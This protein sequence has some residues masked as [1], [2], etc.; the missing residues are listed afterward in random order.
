MSRGQSRPR[1]Q[2]V[3]GV[4][5]RCK[6]RD[7]IEIIDVEKEKIDVVIVDV[8]ETCHQGS[9]HTGIT[10]WNGSPSGVI[11][12]DDEDGDDNNTFA[13]TDAA[14]RE[15]F[16]ASNNSPISEESKSDECII[17]SRKRNPLLKSMEY[18]KNCH[19]V[20]PSNNHFGL[21]SCSKSYSSDSSESNSSKFN[22]GSIYTDSNSS[23]CEI[24]DDSSG[25]VR[26]MW[27]RA[28]SRKKL[29]EK[30]R[31][32]SDQSSASGS[33]GDS[34]L[35]PGGE[36]H[37]KINVE[38][39]IKKIYSDPSK[40]IPVE[41]CPNLSSR[42]KEKL[43][44]NMFGDAENGDSLCNRNVY[45]ADLDVGNLGC[46]E[47]EHKSQSTCKNLSDDQGPHFLASEVPCA[48]V[49]H[50]NMQHDLNIQDDSVSSFEQ[51]E[52]VFFA[53]T[54]AAD[55]LHGESS[56]CSNVGPCSGHVSPLNLQ[57][58]DGE[59]LKLDRSIQGKTKRFHGG[60]S[61]SML[62]QCDS[63]ADPKAFGLQEKEKSS[64]DVPSS[65]NY[66]YS[67]ALQN[68]DGET[69]VKGP[70]DC[71]TNK[72]SKAGVSVPDNGPEDTPEVC[73]NLICER[74]RH[75]ES[76]EY[77]HAIKE[78]WAA[79]QRQL[80]IQAEEAQ[81]MKRKRKAETL[82]LLDMER[83]QKQRLEEI[84]ESQKKD[85][86]TIN[87]KEHIR[88]EVRKELDKMELRYRDMASLL[89]GLGIHVGGG[90]FP[91]PCE[92]NA[93]YKQALLKFHPDRA[94]RSDIHQQV[95]AEE[96]FKMISRLKEKF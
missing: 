67:D 94:S 48:S 88:S 60:A 95:K 93:A 92:V 45:A 58:D 52:S 69:T 46:K 23:D 41:F 70:P 89:R 78:E 63:R 34:G 1:N 32:G 31:C 25:N 55:G 76:D 8:E 4:L 38:N 9:R 54:F 11:N 74:E 42:G 62:P 80:Q 14:D 65:C 30:W 24:I 26:E 64:F 20:G 22:S 35:S 79:R 91:M 18:M 12:I 73:T 15:F 17:T 53:T 19:G 51:D 6:N 84:R 82:R 29:S 77:R 96:T 72:G 40:E 28:A 27:E 57:P 81:R 71:D 33:S 7:T 3:R 85:E 39:C 56:F 49:C 44:F 36:T 21:Y 59:R 10:R 68:V 47:P 16:P 50:T 13:Y 66:C 87:L 75:K 2:S 83:R 90:A 61:S 86:E 43:S 37:T 5:E